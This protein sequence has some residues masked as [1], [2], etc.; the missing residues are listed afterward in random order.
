MKLHKRRVLI[1]GKLSTNEIFDQ[2]ENFFNC[3]FL[4]RLHLLEK[5]AD[6]QN[7]LHP[8]LFSVLCSVWKIPLVPP[9]KTLRNKFG[10]TNKIQRE[11]IKLPKAQGKLTFCKKTS[12]FTLLLGKFPIYMVQQSNINSC[13]TA[14]IEP[15][16]CNTDGKLYLCML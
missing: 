2:M 13:C 14:P 6:R 11:V 4:L 15:E 1:S 8:F 7:S 9:L 3:N 5:F 16:F 12:L 10:R